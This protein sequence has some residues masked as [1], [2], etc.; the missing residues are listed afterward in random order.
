M[1]SSEKN[2]AETLTW[3]FWDRGHEICVKLEQIP[4]RITILTKYDIGA[5]VSC[6]VAHVKVMLIGGLHAK[7]EHG[8][9]GLDL[10]I[11]AVW[12]AINTTTISSS[13]I[14]R[15]DETA[16]EPPILIDLRM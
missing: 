9:S 6:H 16:V 14:E 13:S 10:W 15:K 1:T 8:Q 7:E 11:S 12:G 5:V 4:P 2:E 3:E